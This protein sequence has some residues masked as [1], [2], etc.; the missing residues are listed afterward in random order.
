MKSLVIPGLRHVLQSSEVGSRSG[1]MFEDLH[2]LLSRISPKYV[3]AFAG[4]LGDAL[5]ALSAVE[6]MNHDDS[7]DEE[8][9]GEEEE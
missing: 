7:D 5:D 9:E 3:D 1:V 4:A 6:W 8:E 2:T